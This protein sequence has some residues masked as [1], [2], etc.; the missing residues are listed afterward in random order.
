MVWHTCFSLLTLNR[1]LSDKRGP[2]GQLPPSA[3]LTVPYQALLQPQLNMQVKG[4]R[5]REIT[6]CCLCMYQTL[7]AVRAGRVSV[8]TYVRWT[9]EKIAALSFFSDLCKTRW[10]MFQFRKLTGN[11][12]EGL[13]TSSSGANSTAAPRLGKW[14]RKQ[15]GPS[16]NTQAN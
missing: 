10:Q 2:T 5:K 14:P 8:L 13:R 11:Q 7:S 15:G 16:A 6:T 4:V 9:F 1:L 12:S 3:W